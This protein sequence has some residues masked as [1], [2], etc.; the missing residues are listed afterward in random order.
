MFVVIPRQMAD[1]GEVKFVL[2]HDE[3]RGPQ[4]DTRR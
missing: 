2:A 1:L 4:E 3:R